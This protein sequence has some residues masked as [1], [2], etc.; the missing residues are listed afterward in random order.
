MSNT[1]LVFENSQTGERMTYDLN[2]NLFDLANS[3]QK[4]SLLTAINNR[5]NKN[6]D[7]VRY[8]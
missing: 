8:A 2:S 4:K 5:Y 7:I 6:F 1:V 3:A